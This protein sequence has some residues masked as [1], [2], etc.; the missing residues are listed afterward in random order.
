MLLYN[1]LGVGYLQQLSNLM[2]L[3]SYYIIEGLSH[4]H[5][6]GIGLQLQYYIL[7]FALI[8]SDQRTWRYLRNLYIELRSRT[9]L[10][11]NLHWCC[12]LYSNWSFEICYRLLIFRK[13]SGDYK[14]EASNAAKGVLKTSSAET[15]VLVKYLTL[16]ICF[17]KFTY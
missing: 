4:Y 3:S 11:S 6:P 12:T 5:L 2:I 8:I 10:Q 1:M 9:D 17:V 16:V 15:K 14:C 13:F 7:R